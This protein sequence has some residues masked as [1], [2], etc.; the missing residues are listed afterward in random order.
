MFLIKDNN[1]VWFFCALGM[2]GSTVGSFIWLSGAFKCPTCKS[3]I[4]GKAFQSKSFFTWLDDL[5][6]MSKCPICNNDLIQKK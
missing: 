5:K 6:Y 1:K 2:L 4:G 3:S